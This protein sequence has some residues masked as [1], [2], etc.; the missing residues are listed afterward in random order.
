MAELMTK[1]TRASAETFL[2]SIA[3]E[4]RRQDCLTIA[5]I[6]KQATRADARMWGPSMVGFGSYHYRYA[7]GHEG[8]CFVTGFSPRKQALTLYIMPGVRRYESLTKKLGKHKT[9]K[10][11]LYIKRLA[12]VDLAVL[13]ELIAQSVRQAQAS[14]PKV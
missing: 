11:C 7:S 10:S 6:M 13:K 14:H 8:E 9:G 12:D 2:E 3:D 5:K 4:T 1:P